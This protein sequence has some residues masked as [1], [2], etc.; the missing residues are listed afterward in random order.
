MP[1]FHK[2]VHEVRDPV[3]GFV[4]LTQAEWQIVNQS[5]FQR[6]RDIRQL[7][8]GHLVYPGAA[9]T[10]FEHSLGCLHL[11]TM[12]FDAL[13]ERDRDV[14]DAG[15]QLTDN[16][17][18]RARQV[19]RLA[20][21]LHDVGHPPFS[22]TGESVLPT[23][24]HSDGGL[25]I[26]KHED[27]TA[28]IV[29]TCLKD[30]IDKH[31]GPQGIDSEEVIAIATDFDRAIDFQAHGYHTF[32][33]EL[34]TG[35]LGA[36]RVDYLLR[37]AYH[38][39]QKAGEFD[40]RRLVGSIKMV[41][42]LRQDEVVP[43][44]GFEQGG[45]LVAEQMIAARYFMYMSLY[46]HKTKRICELHLTD[47]LR[48]WLASVGVGTLPADPAQ[49]IQL[50]DSD[51]WAALKAAS[52]DPAQAGH[53]H[54]KRLSDRSHL[55]LAKEVILADNVMQPKTER[56]QPDK[57]RFANLRDHVRIVLGMRISCVRFDE[58][59]HSATKMFGES[60][61]ILIDFE[62]QPRYL[63]AV[64]EVV[65]GMSDKIWRG[66]VYAEKSEREEIRGVC[67]EWLRTHPPEELGPRGGVDGPTD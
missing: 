9:H 28:R 56:R 3:Y 43:R 57:R 61:K 5:A 11:A 54:A 64:S 10:R 24:A 38:S 39:G 21:L 22:H 34:L 26:L 8:M 32:L 30:V 13:V 47:F 40:Y 66:R 17:Q 52:R 6:L 35:E 50:S 44:I 25:R 18:V 48:D 19:I 49:Y 14:L 37:D 65:R 45:W 67:E 41:T 53:E 31:F 27:M 58:P 29:R 62:G 55:R 4:K 23:E 16:A 42:P 2:A 7:A 33:H 15:F 1:S 60:N 20:A 46:F 63:D 12:M 36:D 51:V 59:D